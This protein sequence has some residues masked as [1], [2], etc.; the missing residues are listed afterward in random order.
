MPK[1]TRVLKIPP[2]FQRLLTVSSLFQQLSQPTKP[3][4]NATLPP[5]HNTKFQNPEKQRK[6]DF[7]KCE[8]FFPFLSFHFISTNFV[9]QIKS[10]KNGKFREGIVNGDIQT[11]R[12]LK[13]TFASESQ[14]LLV[15]RNPALLRSD[16]AVRDRQRPR[17]PHAPPPPPRDRRIA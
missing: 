5:L 6:K 15:V 7:P 4:A 12:F 9:T 11:V 1:M 17:P 13:R 8:F 14:P 2:H 16:R 10:L 3:R